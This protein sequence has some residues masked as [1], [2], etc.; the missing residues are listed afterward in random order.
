MF[1]SQVNKSLGQVD[2][3]ARGPG[4]QFPVTAVTKEHKL[5]QTG[6]LTMT[7]TCSVAILETGCLKSRCRSG[8]IQ[9]SRG[10]FLAS[11]SFCSPSFLGL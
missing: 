9:T 7:N 1:I 6:W 5:A 10:P 4:C 2:S 11:S 8:L 3:L